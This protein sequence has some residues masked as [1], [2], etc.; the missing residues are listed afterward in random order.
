MGSVSSQK[1]E[2]GLSVVL[3]NGRY[4]TYD[5]ISDI[6]FGGPF[7]FVEKGEDVGGLIKGFRD[8]LPL[9]GVLTML[10]PFTNS[11]KSSW[12]GTK[13]LV[14]KPNDVSGIGKLMRFRDRLLTERIAENET[15][16]SR[17]RIDLLQM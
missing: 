16:K 5:V 8:G 13:F 2:R 11:V 10:Y 4:M 15:G 9:F 12:F 17:E 14:S 7:G 1:S 6:G 3:M